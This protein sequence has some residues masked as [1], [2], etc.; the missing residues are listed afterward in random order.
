MRTVRHRKPENFL[1]GLS[2]NGHGIQVEEILSSREAVDEALVMGLRL[3]EGIDI[4]A[5]ATRFSNDDVV[6]WVRVD[7]LVQSGHLERKGARIALSDRGRLL[8]D[9]ILG[10]IVVA[11]PRISAV[12]RQQV[13]GR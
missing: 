8:L 11:E 7:R 5:V 6:D 10:D 13:S 3:R 2:R 9:Y 12:G 1:S 4:E